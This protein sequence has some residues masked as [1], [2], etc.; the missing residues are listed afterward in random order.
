MSLF[1]LCQWLEAA[2]IGVHVREDI[3]TFPVLIA[4]HML[5]LTLSV[6]TLLWFDLRLMGFGVSNC[7]VSRLYRRLMP[8]M[9]PSFLI[10][11]VSGSMIFAG[12]ATLAYENVY[13]KIK[14]AALVVAGLNAMLFHVF[15]EKRLGPWDDARVLPFPARVAGFVSILAWLTVILSGRMI[16]YTMYNAGF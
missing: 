14:L 15:T 5:G 10:M 12:F 1:E 3:W 6:G 4:V 8:L 7:S 2:S 11:A 13:F 9:L 16:S